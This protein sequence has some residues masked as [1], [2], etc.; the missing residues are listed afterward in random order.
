MEITE[1]I[2]E[3]GVVGAGGAG[4]PTHAKVRR[5]LETVIANGAEC[6]PLLSNDKYVLAEHGEDVIQGLELILKA[7]GAR[8]GI[9]AIKKKNTDVVSSVEKIIESRKNLFLALLGDFYPAGDELILV[10]LTTGKLVPQ[11][12]LPL[13]VDCMVSNVETLRNV[14]QASLGKPVT[15]RTLTCAGEVKNPSV[16]VTH[17][18]ASIQDV[19]DACGG[20]I[21]EDPAVIIGGPMMGSVE[22]DFNALVTKTMTGIIVLPSDHFLIQKKNLSMPWVIKQSKVACC[23]CTYCTELCPRYLLGHELYPHKIMRSINLGLSVPPE[24]VESA[25]LCSECGLCEVYACPMGL[26][27][28]MVNRAIKNSLLESGYRP[29]FDSEK[30]ISRR[31][32]L[33]NRKIPTSKIKNRL[34]IEKYDRE[35]IAGIVET[36][37][38][39]VEILLKQHIG[40][41]SIPVVEVGDKVEEGDL[42][43]DI[44]EKSLG[45]KIHASIKGRVSFVDQERII[46]KRES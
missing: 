2:R 31:D 46:I 26:S 39:K 22:R 11:G 45:A 16:V 10:S 7:S 12:K 36:N 13:S 3:A 29:H 9:I 18:G 28:R 14:Y 21:V 38:S 34:Q 15:R 43:A 6:E 27:P 4:F 44:P 37:P 33:L 25:F 5:G 41:P 19:I 32:D 17:I 40:L 30:V 23:Q 35:K 8:E 42:L 24:V 1:T 20:I